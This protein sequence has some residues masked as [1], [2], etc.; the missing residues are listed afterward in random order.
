MRQSGILRFLYGTA[1]GLSIPGGLGMLL[2][3]GLI[4]LALMAVAGTMMKASGTA[5]VLW[6]PLAMAD[7][8]LAIWALISICIRVA[9]G[10]PT[11]NELPDA[12][13]AGGMDQAMGPRVIEK[14]RMK[15]MLA[16]AGC[17]A[18]ALVCLPLLHNAD[19]TKQWSGWAGLVFFGGGGLVLLLSAFSGNGALALDEDGFTLSSALRKFRYEWRDVS[20]FSVIRIG[21]AR[22]QMVGF[23]IINKPGIMHN[24]AQDMTGTGGALMN[25]YTLPPAELAALMNAYRNTACNRRDRR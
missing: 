9:K 15:Q 21:R 14:S 17:L 3:D 24:F 10:A 19:I 25:I 5:R 23:S 7:L 12:F 13:P 18:M 16:M 8:L 22:T 2:L 20:P 6:L 11:A 4:F 1:P